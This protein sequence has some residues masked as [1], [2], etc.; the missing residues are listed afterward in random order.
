MLLAKVLTLVIVVGTGFQIFVS[1]GTVSTEIV[2][3]HEWQ[4]LSPYIREVWGTSP[5]TIA[6]EQQALL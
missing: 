4:A 3:C 1:F 2:S 6:K 5:N